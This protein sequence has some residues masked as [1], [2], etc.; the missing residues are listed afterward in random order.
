[1][2]RLVSIFLTLTLLM[3]LFS[4][5]DVSAVTNEK[6]LVDLIA[7][8]N[9]TVGDL[10]NYTPYQCDSAVKGGHT[11]EGV[12]RIGDGTETGYTDYSKGF[13]YHSAS[14]GSARTIT[15]AM[16]EGYNTISGIVGVCYHVPGVDSGNETHYCEECYVTIT[17]NS[18][19]IYNS[20][21]IKVK[22]GYPFKVRAREGS[23]VIISV[24]NPTS[25]GSYNHVIFG[26]PKLSYED[27]PDIDLSFDK[28]VYLAGETA[29]PVI[30]GSE[31]DNYTIKWYLDGVELPE[32]TDSYPVKKSDMGKTL[33]MVA[34]DKE[35]I[36]ITTAERYLSKLTVVSV[37]TETGQDVTSK[38]DYID[39]N[40]KIYGNEEFGGET[41]YSG[42]TEIR[43]R[44]NT[45]WGFPKKSYKLK[46]D[47]KTN[48]CGMGKIST[49][50]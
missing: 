34:C 14:G 16:P 50:P 28:P 42:L 22:Q 43:G 6:Y 47:K 17:V 36:V 25:N 2:K 49:G 37:E 40:L 9:A 38:E 29:T 1:M 30:T 41:Q 39:A 3:S 7:E 46:L 8:G 4:M 11:S 31:A 32:V 15:F 27:Y 10:A 18:A 35:G 20:G 44:G 5:V 26:D 19:S 24:I 45:S 23:N 48:L 33:K 21:A 12:V 13:R